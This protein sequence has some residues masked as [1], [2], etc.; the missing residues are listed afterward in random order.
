MTGADHMDQ[1]DQPVPWAEREARWADLFF[2][3][4]SKSQKGR[5]FVFGAKRAFKIAKNRQ[6]ADF[7]K[8]K[9]AKFM[10][11]RGEKKV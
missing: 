9:G 2:Y 8:P 1:Q 7:K 3:P 6:K 11:K 4:F 10:S 5:I